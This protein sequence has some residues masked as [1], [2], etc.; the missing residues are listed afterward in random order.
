MLTPDAG[1]GS[2]GPARE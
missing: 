2:K 1:G